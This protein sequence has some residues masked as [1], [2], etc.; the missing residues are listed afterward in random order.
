MATITIE[1]GGPTEAR[2]RMRASAAGKPVE[3]FVGEMLEAEDSAAGF[4]RDLSGPIA[5]KVRAL[6]MTEEELAE[7][8]ER[9]DRGTRG[10][11]YDD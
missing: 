7:Q 3:Q 10:V 8:L 1:I 9:E 6:R 2:L 4:L 5:E 11:P